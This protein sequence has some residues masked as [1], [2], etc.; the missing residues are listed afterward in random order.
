MTC[1]TNRPNESIPVF[2]SHRPRTRPRRTSQAA[3]YCKAP[4]RLYSCSTRIGRPG[5]GRQRR[6]TSDAGLNAGLLVR[7]DDVVPAAQRLALPGASVQVK[8]TPSFFGELRI[9]REY[10]VLIPPWLDG[11][12]VEDAPD[13]A[14]ADRST[15]GRRC[16][17]GQVRSRQP[18]Q[19]QLGLADRLTGDCLDD[20]PVARGK[21]R[22]CVPRPA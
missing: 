7:A 10:P 18:T 4:P 15:Q 16:L 9:A 2:S 14:V 21:K 1:S 20:C 13:G 3:R 22:A 6:V 11:V 19:W 17:I 8:D 5:A 12:G